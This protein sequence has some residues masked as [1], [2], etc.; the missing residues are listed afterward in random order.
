[1]MD[2]FE[3]T[4]IAGAVLTALLVI[5]G[6][7]TII[8]INTSGHGHGESHSGYILPAA[9]ADSGTQKP[10]K[11]APAF[12]P[13]AIAATAANADAAAGETVFKKCAACHTIDNGGPNKTGPNLFGIVGRP[14]ASHAGFNYSD[15]MKAKGGNWDLTDLAHFLHKPKEFIAKTKMSF[16]GIPD[17][18]DLANLLA[19]LSKQK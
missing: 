8:E 4:K 19:Y 14:K 11:A 12:D 15:D 9:E 17:T 16:G 6:T 1:M 10:A 3:L 5:F 7:K 18:G 2:S 13:A